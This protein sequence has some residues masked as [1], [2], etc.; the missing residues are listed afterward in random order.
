MVAVPCH[1]VGTFTGRSGTIFGMSKKQTDDGWKWK[2][3][4]SAP[5]NI[6]GHQQPIELASR[7]LFSSVSRAKME[8]CYIK[9]M[10][11][12]YNVVVSSGQ[13]NNEAEQVPYKYLH[14]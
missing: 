12:L 4:L 3:W 1:T 5:I 10:H 9:I 8:Q 6:G 7:D 13:Q 11:W 14:L 2:R